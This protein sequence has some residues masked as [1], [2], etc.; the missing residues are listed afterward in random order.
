MGKL[1]YYSK[2]YVNQFITDENNSIIN[3]ICIFFNDKKKY[4]NLSIKYEKIKYVCFSSDEVISFIK[5]T[6]SKYIETFSLKKWL[7]MNHIKKITNIFI[8]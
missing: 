4:N 7:L 3:N 1:N 5:Q 6:S 2:K 8:N